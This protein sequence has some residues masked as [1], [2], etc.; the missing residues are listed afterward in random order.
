MA[1]EEEGASNPSAQFA[2]ALNRHGYGFQQAVATR[3]AELRRNGKTRWGVD[4]SEFP[5]AVGGANTHIDLVLR[6]EGT[7]TYLVAEC[8]RVDPAIGR[9]CFA[10]TYPWGAR[11]HQNAV[12]F[13][14]L[15]FHQDSKLHS[16]PLKIPWSTEPYQVGVEVRTLTKG[17]G[18]GGAND[19]IEKSVT[20]SLRGASGLA[21]YF[22]SLD[23]ETLAT[24]SFGIIPVVVTTAELWVTELDLRTT[25]LVSGNVSKE[26]LNAQNVGWLWFNYNISL[27]LRNSVGATIEPDNLS[28]ALDAE[29]TR[30]VALVNP[31][32]LDDFLKLDLELK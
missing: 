17:D 12:I 23:F 26:K 5:V 22:Y 25:D 9:W 8:K 19:A 31:D 7:D 10:R 30:S 24:R 28:E 18:A 4:V 13:E 14:R 15:A 32:G 29:A 2:N 3:V 20:Q 11:S 6:V 16:R 21:N 27:N 1:D